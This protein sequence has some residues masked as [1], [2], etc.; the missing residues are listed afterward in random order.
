VTCLPEIATLSH[1]HPWVLTMVAGRFGNDNAQT[2][3][4]S[5]QARRSK[6][7][8]PAVEKDD[9]E[10]AE[11]DSFRGVYDQLSP[12]D[13]RL[14]RILGVFGSNDFSRGPVQVMSPNSQ[15]LAELGKWSLV[16]FDGSRYALHPLVAQFALEL[17][18]ADGQI[19][20]TRSKMAD[21]YLQFVEARSE[22]SEVLYNE[23]ERELS[24]ILSCTAWLNEQTKDPVGSAQTK[25]N[26]LIKFALGLRSF[27]DAR[28]HWLENMA[29]HEQALALARRFGDEDRVGE[30]GNAL[31]S[32]YE[33]RGEDQK[34]KSV[35]R[36]TASKRMLQEEEEV[37]RALREA[38]R[39]AA[40]NGR[41]REAERLYSDGVHRA[42]QYQRPEMK[43]DLLLELAKLSR[44][45]GN[46][47]AAQTH[48]AN[49]LTIYKSLANRTGEGLVDEE[50]RQLENVRKEL[51]LKL[52]EE[53]GRERQFA[54]IA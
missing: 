44:V 33:K 35:R 49:A 19:V 37:T 20:E 53:V 39:D 27:L 38:A 36:D 31:A 10:K 50:T 14:C 48:C 12:D 6:T 11:L 29:I 24:N 47:E 17:L 54:A 8:A 45:D 32:I 30:L 46:I 25:D 51:K 43:A 52:E 3:L 23:L 18:A 5:L 41:R 7:D 28:G 13:Q 21:Y 40:S 1:H 16:Q 9:L 42:E 26:R 34:S 4:T 15:R 2:I 22:P